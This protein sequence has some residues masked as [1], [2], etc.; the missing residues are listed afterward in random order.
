M[1][2][3]VGI[4]VGLV[5][6]ALAGLLN[7]TINKALLKKG[8]TNALMAGNLAR[9]A[10]DFAAMAAVY[11]LRNLLPFSW[12]AALIGTAVALSIVTIIFA[13]NYGKN[14]K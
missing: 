14:S 6:G 4:L 8:T 3:A 7:T 5:W 12:E 1:K 11:L 2:L 10:V 13:F 9:L